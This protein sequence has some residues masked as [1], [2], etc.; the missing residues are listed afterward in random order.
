MDKIIQFGRQEVG[1][2]RMEIQTA[3]DN[4]KSKYELSELTLESITYS[5]NSFTSKIRCKINDFEEIR[6]DI[7][8][9]MLFA[10]RYGLP[11][12]FINREFKTNGLNYKITRIETRNIKYPIIAIC[13]ENE[14]TYKF[15]V[16]R[17]KEILGINEDK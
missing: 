11:E 17:I 9:N 14:R 4:I 10:L 6:T 8:E 12:N 2:L 3:L 5:D 13:K 7:D 15:S 16:I 1:L